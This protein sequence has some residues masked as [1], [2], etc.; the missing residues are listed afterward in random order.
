MKKIFFIYLFLVSIHSFS[1]LNKKDY[2]GKWKVVNM[3]VKILDDDSQKTIVEKAALKKLISSKFED[4]NIYIELSKNTFT[5]IENGKISEKYKIKSMK[6]TEGKLELTFDKYK[7]TFFLKN[8]DEGE[9]S[10]D[11][12]THYLKKE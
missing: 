7:K 4:E 2:Y 11:G 3:E 5:Y 8:K 6:L 10:G 1:Q 12:I 9:L